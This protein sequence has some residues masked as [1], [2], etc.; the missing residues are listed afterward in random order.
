MGFQFP[1]AKR[2]AILL[3]YVEG[4]KAIDCDFKIWRSAWQEERMQCEDKHVKVAKF[5]VT[6]YIN[7]IASY[8]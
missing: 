5:R 7:K 6:R 8:M 3:R 1:F 4:L 2:L